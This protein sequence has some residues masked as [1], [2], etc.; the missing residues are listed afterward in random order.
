MV[1]AAWAT[2]LGWHQDAGDDTVSFAVT[3]TADQTNDVSVAGLEPVPLRVDLG[4]SLRTIDQQVSN[5]RELFNSSCAH[6]LWSFEEIC[7]LSDGESAT[8]RTHV[9]EPFI[10]SLP[11]TRISHKLFERFNIN[12]SV[13]EAEDMNG[14]CS[15]WF[16]SSVPE[17]K[18]EVILQHF[19][20][21][22]KAFLNGD[23]F[24]LCSDISLMPEHEG[25]FLEDIAKAAKEPDE[26]LVLDL[27]EQ[28]AS[29]TPHKAAVQFEKDCVLSYR[30]LNELAN[31]VARQLTC[32]RGDLV[33]V[34]ISR[35][36]NLIVALLAVLKT[37][38]AYVPLDPDVAQNRNEFIVKDVSAPMVIC[39]AYVPHRISKAVQMETLIELSSW[40]D[41]TNLAVEQ[42]ATDI[43]Y[44][45]YTSGSTGSP[46]GVLL[47]HRAAY[48]GLLAFPNLPNLRQLLF[49]NPVFSAAQR[50]VWSTLKQGGCLCIASKANLTVNIAETIQKMEISV[51]D[52]TPSNAS[53]IVPG[54]V[55]SLKRMTIAGELINPALIPPWINRLELLNAYGLSENTQFNWRHTIKHGQNPQNIGRPVDTTSA[56]VLIPGTTKLSP[57]LV[58][59]ELCLGG[60]QLAR[61][62]LN[63]PE[64]TAE[65]FVPNPFGEGRLYR[66]G[67]MVVAHE[68]G[69]IEMI[70][71][72]DFQVKINDQR[73][74][75]GEANA[76]LQVHPEVSDSAV[77][78]A[79]VRT[80]KAL[81]AA[82][83]PRI[84]SP[85]PELQHRLKSHLAKRLPSYMIP[86]FWTAFEKLPLNI[87]GKID[88]PSLR[89]TLESLAQNGDLQRK[90]S[91]ASP[92]RDKSNMSQQ[93]E[94]IASLWGE[95]LNM[96]P[97]EIERSSKFD[98]L[99]GTSLEAI[100]VSSQGRKNGIKIEVAQILEA[101]SLAK[102][103]SNAIFDVN[104]ACSLIKPT[105]FELAGRYNAH[106]FRGAIDAYPATAMQREIIA[107]HIISSGNYV[108]DRAYYLG[109]DITSLLGALEKVLQSSDVYRTIFQ[110]RGR[111]IFQVVLNS[112]QVNFNYF[113]GD[114]DQYL[115]ER[116]DPKK[117]LG[118]GAKM[119]E[120]T[121]VNNTILVVTMHHALFDFWSHDFLIDDIRACLEG[122]EI[123]KRPPF[124]LYMQYL[125]NKDR[126]E[127]EQFWRH[128]LQN[129]TLTFLQRSS[130][131]ATFKSTD[132]GLNIA[133]IAAENKITVPSLVYA[134]WAL[135]LSKQLKSSDVI[136]GITLSGRDAPIMD[137]E[138]MPGPLL[139]TAPL[140]VQ[141][142]S[143]Q[144]VADLA[145]RIMSDIWKI[146][147][148]AYLGLSDILACANIPKDACLSLVNFLIS[149][150]TSNHEEQ[151]LLRPIPIPQIPV[152][153]R[154]V[155][156][157][158]YNS[159]QD[160]RI[161]STTGYAEADMMLPTIQELLDHSAM[162][163]E[164]P[165]LD[166]KARHKSRDRSLQSEDLDC[167]LPG[168]GMKISLD[169]NATS[170]AQR[171]GVSLT[172]LFCSA[173]AILLS[174]RHSSTTALFRIS[175]TLDVSQDTLV[176]VNLDLCRSLEDLYHCVQRSFGL[177]Q[178]ETH[179]EYPPS[180]NNICLASEELPDYHNDRFSSQILLATMENS[181]DISIRLSPQILD[182]QYFCEGYHSIL[183]SLQ[184]FDLKH[185]IQS[186]SA[187]GSTERDYLL[188][189]A[190]FESTSQSSLQSRFE[191][192]ARSKPYLHA[193]EWEKKQTVCYG[194]LNNEA[195][196]FARQLSF[197][198]VKPDSPIGLLM[199]KS[200]DAIIS[201]LA[202]LKA[203]AYFIPLNTDNT[204]SRNN[205][206]V[207]EARI[208]FVICNNSSLGCLPKV[209]EIRPLNVDVMRGSI[210]PF[211]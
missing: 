110:G 54:S 6:A 34:C 135:A 189:L 180:I 22:L 65:A 201:M 128:Y 71:R 1:F 170:L 39:D 133:R 130:N 156:E 61:G 111:T 99:G 64:K 93:E 141:I 28:Q 157:V 162:P 106:H 158:E 10:T 179:D 163:L 164:S 5:V 144:S 175:S 114:L 46:K 50:S 98:E 48:S 82:I 101:T 43:C 35:S 199:E 198:G 40:N 53:L 125:A 153:D 109:T 186:L 7:S 149:A 17:G 83:I 121:V 55:P 72:I 52:L 115:K 123:P 19:K 44:V 154:L 204:S 171:H 45:I 129:T 76:L 49:H 69:S 192:F 117:Q 211:A 177:K 181:T 147:I 27:F 146:S 190:K 2:V 120:M 122:L 4:N 150:E 62:Y 140:R 210:E 105:P 77:V 94:I 23:S 84:P 21:A 138:H 38:A 24:A 193:I 9:V 33:P 26:G 174:E 29:Q 63:R 176:F 3:P 159:M 116:R 13:G 137:V 195:E 132:V 102:L 92:V 160:M 124:S 67:D 57:L 209:E 78:S 41:S 47:E 165:R 126:Q 66:T 107:D 87:N 59:G 208:S 127:S 97:G 143:N 16:D 207:H 30:Q 90:A 188:S 68:D 25:V 173:W 15:M 172:T 139:M 103:A 182:G 187:I 169:F 11:L 134:C 148:H 112:N 75:P 56:Y 96:K 152:S 32:R 80:K 196:A 168:T 197:A 88:V 145:R 85:W 151:S 113:E 203:G 91:S 70:G 36:I 104:S 183:Q 31:R 131:T 81:V 161:M 42:D 184:S 194:D 185:E 37:G 142:Q 155:L 119:I 136:F 118:L 12:V 178:N 73:V 108:Y 79:Q 200:V 191:G 202:I 20:E 74:E 100:K 8:F 14:I 51:I 206:I 205:F 167:Q 60:H 86:T 166:N 18:A 95:A 58:P 89:K